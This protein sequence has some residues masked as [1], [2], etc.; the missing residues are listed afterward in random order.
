MLFRWLEFHQPLPWQTTFKMATLRDCINF[1]RDFC[2]F[3]ND[4][5]IFISNIKMIWIVKLYLW[6]YWDEII[7]TF[8]GQWLRIKESTP[9]SVNNNVNL[10]N[11]TCTRYTFVKINPCTVR[12]ITRYKTSLVVYTAMFSERISALGKVRADINRS[13][14]H[15]R[16]AFSGQ[17]FLWMDSDKM[18]AC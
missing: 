15:T 10:R 1:T 9:A 2:W 8:E 13:D 16:S 6:T 7:S 14:F 4:I 17:I 18:A 3:R 11:L 12:E 5:F